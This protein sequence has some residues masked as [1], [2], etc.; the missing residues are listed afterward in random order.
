MEHLIEIVSFEG[1]SNDNK[2]VQIG[3]KPLEAD[4]HYQL[5]VTDWFRT[6]SGHQLKPYL[7]DIQTKS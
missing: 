3:I 1:F 7:I 6:K 2:T 5:V 4:K